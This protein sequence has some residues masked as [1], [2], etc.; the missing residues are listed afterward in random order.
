MDYYVM[1]GASGDGVIGHMLEL[2]GDAPMFL[3][4]ICGCWQSKERYNSQDE[5]VGVVKQYREPGVP[6]DGI[7]RT[8]LNGRLSLPILL[9]ALTA[10]CLAQARSENWVID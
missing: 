1:S 8:F 4:W 9:S 2:T 3:L 7:K 5:L 6:L 10:S